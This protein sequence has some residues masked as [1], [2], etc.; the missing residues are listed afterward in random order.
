MWGRHRV[1]HQTAGLN[2]NHLA[3]RGA[4]QPLGPAVSSCAVGMVRVMKIDKQDGK[5]SPTA[6]TL[7]K[8]ASYK[9]IL[10]GSNYMTY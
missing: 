5:G 6:I 9:V 4:A 8:E 10:D 3:A 7:R 1:Q 2:L